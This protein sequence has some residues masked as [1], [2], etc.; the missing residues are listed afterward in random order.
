[1]LVSVLSH[2]PSCR[3]SSVKLQGYTQSLSDEVCAF[4]DKVDE[5]ISQDEAVNKVCCS[6]MD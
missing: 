2:L 5:L 3:W 6:L 4:S 1:M